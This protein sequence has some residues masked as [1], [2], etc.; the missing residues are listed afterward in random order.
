MRR[1]SAIVVVLFVALLHAASA[2]AQ[3]LSGFTIRGRVVDPT[4]APLPGAVVTDTPEPR[5]TARSTV[6]DQTGH[7]TLLLDRGTHTLTI[8]SAGFTDAVLS[9]TARDNGTEMRE[10]VLQLAGVRER[11]K[12][13]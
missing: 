7:F 12:C 1:V 10:V 5:G 4:R 3:A 11:I 8:S 2:S 6:T 9:V 13:V